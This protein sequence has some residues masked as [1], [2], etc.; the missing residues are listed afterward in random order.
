M[1]NKTKLT[2]RL[3]FLG[4]EFSQKRVMFLE[5]LT[6]GLQHMPASLHV[7][8]QNCRD[9]SSVFKLNTKYAYGTFGEGSQIR[10]EK[11]LY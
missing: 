4:G 10:S 9:F 6:V 11:T 3:K 7:P 8:K 1:K 5:L 2:D